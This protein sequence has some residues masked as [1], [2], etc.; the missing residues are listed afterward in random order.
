MPRNITKARVKAGNSQAA[1]IERRQAFV[2]AYLINGR[3]ATQA[4]IT[5]GYS[6]KTAYSQGQRLLKNVEVANQVVAAV[7]KV[8]A[9]TGLTLE[10]TLQ[11][12]ARL[13]FFD[14][15]KL[16]RDGVLIPVHELDDDTAAAVA[17]IE[18]DEI[19]GDGAIIGRTRK[20]KFWDKNAALEKAMRHLGAYEKDNAQRGPDIA[21]QVV[22]VGPT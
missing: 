14:A 10:R 3:N 9:I 6:K 7:E 16:Y 15:R 8:Q 4:A 22:M 12:V 2:A 1:A 19:T 18:T 13:S 11:E 17:A 5:A 20:L 21:M